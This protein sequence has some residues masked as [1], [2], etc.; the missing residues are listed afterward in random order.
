[1][2]APGNS[3]TLVAVDWGTSRLRMRVL[4]GDRGGEVLAEHVSD[5]GI[6]VVPA[7]QH[8]AVF[9]GNLELLLAPWNGAMGFS[10]AGG[11]VY[12]SGMVTSTLGWFPTPYLTLPAGPRDV[13]AGLRTETIR[14]IKLHFLPGLRT[15]DDILRG[16]E[17][18]AIGILAGGGGAPPASA[19]LVLPGTHSKWIRWE[20]GRIGHF[21]T[22]PT[23]DLHAALHRATLLA[24][25][26]PPA[27]VVVQGELWGPFDR[28]VDLAR[29][30]GP[31]ASLFRVRSLP[32]LEGMPRPAA[33]ALLSGILIGGEVL[34]RTRG[35]AFLPALV[36]GAPPLR[37]LYLR[38]F[39]R[40]G[41]AAEGVP[42]DLAE[43]APAEGL[44]VLRGLAGGR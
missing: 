36:G 13:A 17:V 40:L 32:V 31:L 33:S 9:I 44:R 22:V 14:G 18:E 7:R 35:G 19:N 12:F 20:G 4:S 28:G 29:N 6:A 38:A 15:P 3:P 43:R 39:A 25:T 11:E 27:P 1:L 8:E 2:N 5:S 26:L 34:E 21:V 41:L 30:A 37:D 10:A 16:E 23:G 42:P 24:R